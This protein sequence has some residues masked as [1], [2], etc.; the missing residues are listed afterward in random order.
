MVPPAMV[1]T[2]PPAMVPTVP[3][4]MVPTVPP[5]GYG[6]YGAMPYGNAPGA[7]PGYAAPSVVAPAA[8]GVDAKDQE[9]EALKRRIEQLETARQ[10]APPST[11][12]AGGWPSAPAFRPADQY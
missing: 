11:G 12:A 8:G 4:A 2:V 7:A 3:P 10:S 5:P 1:P 9:I 6:A